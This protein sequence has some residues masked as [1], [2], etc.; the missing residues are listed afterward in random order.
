M[1]CAKVSITGYTVHHEGHNL[2]VFLINGTALLMTKL[3]YNKI[4]YRH[5]VS[6]IPKCVIVEKIHCQPCFCH[7]LISLLLH[8]QWARQQVF[9]SSACQLYRIIVSWRRSEI[10][11]INIA[12]VKERVAFRQHTWYKFTTHNPLKQ[13]YRLKF[14]NWTAEE[15][16]YW[17]FQQSKNTTVWSDLYWR[18]PVTGTICLP[19]LRSDCIRLCS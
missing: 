2:E 5:S 11:H 9:F 19:W 4:Y 17:W 12:S 14:Q 13:D 18:P 1:V 8:L 6:R 16:S 15:F 7:F 3:M 10:N